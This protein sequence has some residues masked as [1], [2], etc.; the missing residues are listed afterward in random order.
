MTLYFTGPTWNIFE[1]AEPMRLVE[2]ADSIKISP[3]VELTDTQM[4]EEMQYE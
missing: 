3:P 2:E 1:G 4:M